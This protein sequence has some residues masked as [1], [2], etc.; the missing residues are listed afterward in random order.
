[1][2]PRHKLGVICEPFD[3]KYPPQPQ[4]CFCVHSKS[5][6]NFKSMFPIQSS[7]EFQIVI[8]KAGVN[9]SYWHTLSFS[10]NNPSAQGG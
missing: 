8:K 5:L 7:S 4:Y 3:S 6:F 9:H 1:M 10:G 2:T